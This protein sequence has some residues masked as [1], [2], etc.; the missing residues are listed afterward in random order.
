MSLYQLEILRH[1]ERKTALGNLKE[2]YF[3]G[4][5]IIIGLFL[6]FLP[7]WDPFKKIT[8]LDKLCQFG[9]T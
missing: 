8:N 4:I 1:K 2:T 6:F 3:G 7:K 5:L 9:T